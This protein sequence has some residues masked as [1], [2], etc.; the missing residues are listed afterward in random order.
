MYTCPHFSISPLLLSSL[1]SFPLS[2]PYSLPSPFLSPL[3]LS[4]PLP[5]SSL[6]PS[7]PSYSIVCG[8][9]V[10]SNVFSVLSQHQYD[11]VASPVDLL[12]QSGPASTGIT[13]LW[14]V[15]HTPPHSA[16]I[17]LPSPVLHPPLHL[18]SPLSP[19]PS[20]L[21][22]P[23][24]SHRMPILFKGIYGGRFL[25]AIFFLCL[26][27]AGLSSLISFVEL[28]VHTLTDYGRKGRGGGWT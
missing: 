14:L 5:A 10:F 28:L 25:A 11:N 26:T 17:S 21:S 27:L 2:L 6:L 13:F 1:S 23:S 22:P 20:P 15:N 8:I 18:P 9:M 3:S 24:H 7:S 12:K 19:L 16:H 4:L